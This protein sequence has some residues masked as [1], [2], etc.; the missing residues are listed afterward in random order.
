MGEAEFYEKL[1]ETMAPYI[2]F[3][4]LVLIILFIGKKIRNR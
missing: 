3:A 4:L 1:G 2:F